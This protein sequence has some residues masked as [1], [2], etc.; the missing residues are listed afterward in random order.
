MKCSYN[1]RD[2]SKPNKHN[3]Y[4]RNLY[5]NSENGKIAGVCAG[6]ADYFD[7]PDWLA[8]LVF[9][10]IV[11]FT[12]QLALIGY[13]IAIFMMAKRPQTLQNGHRSAG[14]NNRYSAGVQRERKVFNYAKS[15]SSRLEDISD[16]LKRLDKQVGVMESYV[17]SNK[18]QTN[19]EINKL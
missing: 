7:V 3:G 19:S 10:S 16:R 17:T 15:A 8:R 11:I 1:Q 18:Y 4:L 6:F 14:D 12:F 5:R 9:I 2:P 13:V